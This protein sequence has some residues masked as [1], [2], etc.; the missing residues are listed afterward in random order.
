MTWRKLDPKKLDDP[1]K[2]PWMTIAETQEA[3]GGISNSRVYALKD[4]GKL[5]VWANITPIRITTESVM[6]QIEIKTEKTS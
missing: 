4:E 1:K 5:K 6:L 2:Y 3:L